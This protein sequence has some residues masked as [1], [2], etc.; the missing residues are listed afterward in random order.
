MPA[1]PVKTSILPAGSLA[2]ADFKIEFE[3]LYDYMV[4]LLGASGT[5]ADARTALGAAENAAVIKTTGAQTKAGVL[6][7]SDEPV[8]PAATLS[9]SP[10]RKSQLDAETS[11]LTA[12]IAAALAPAA[13]AP[14]L[15]QRLSASG[16]PASG[17]AVDIGGVPAW[18]NRVTVLFHGLSVNGTSSMMVQIGD[19]G[20]IETSGYQGASGIIAA[21]SAASTAFTT[22]FGLRTTDTSDVISGALVLTRMGGN[23]WVASAS[24]G[25]ESTAAVGTSGGSKTLSA[26]LTQIRVTTVGGSNTFDAG[27]INVLCE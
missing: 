6:T 23:S 13:L 15:L 17:V 16:A 1:P 18:S 8:V 4:A 11:A 12:A 26:A 9:T 24:F 27:S 19:S 22:G 10:V 21:A 5:A 7:L 14:T 25:F 20:G 2:P 3:K